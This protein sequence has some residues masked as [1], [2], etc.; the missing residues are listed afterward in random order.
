AELAAIVR[1]FETFKDQ[2]FN[3]VTDSA[4]V[5]GVAM[6][7][8]HAFLKEESNRNL[9][10]LLS[11]L[12]YLISHRKQRFHVMHVRSHTDL[13]GAIVEVNR[14][15]DVLAMQAQL[16]SRLDVFKQAKLSH[17]FYHQNVLAPARMFHLTREQAKAVVGS[18][19]QCQSYQVPFSDRGV[20]P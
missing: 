7:A 9:Y 16:P 8:E 20:N 15:A 3:L 18:C 4:Y 19:S 6:R 14:R 13:P 17:Q 12:V 11:K 1:A 2:P 5:A 10:N